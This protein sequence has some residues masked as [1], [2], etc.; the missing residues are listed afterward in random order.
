VTPR[1][2]HFGGT[3]VLDDD[4]TG[5]QA[6]VN[7]TVILDPDPSFLSTWT[8]DRRPGTVFVST[9]TRAMSGAKATALTAKIVD[10]VRGNW[11]TARFVMR[12]DSTLRGHVL[13]EYLG[14]VGAARPTL[15]LLPALP[16]AGRITRGGVHYIERDGRI[17]RLDQTEYAG[18]ADFA[19]TSSNLGRWAEERSSGLFSS[20]RTVV[21]EV[22]ELRRR[23]AAA[24][25]DTL[26]R[27][28]GMRPPALCVIDAEREDDLRLAADA[29]E[30]AQATGLRSAI[31]CG[32]DLAALLGRCHAEKLVT[33][34][35]GSRV[36]VIAG[37][38]V[39]T[40]TRQLRRLDERFPDS[41]AE[42]D[43]GRLLSEPEVEVRRLRTEVERLWGQ[44]AVATVATPRQTPAAGVLAGDLG[45]RVAEGMADL[46]RRLH[47]SADL[48][49]AKGGITAAVIAARAFGANTAWVEGPVRAGVSLWSLSSNDHEQGSLVVF[50]GNVGGNEDLA[51]LVEEATSA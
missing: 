51:D 10:A 30:E 35:R 3:V 49:V 4:P 36:L 13:E 19:Y 38:Y 18:D 12:G 1:S 31:R 42:V 28:E 43:L 50:P 2:H 29:L 26:R 44:S 37:S 23:G 14:V 25:T 46:V 5:A 17:V 24:L 15:V 45:R 6:S 39:P 47:A 48:V 32:P 9:N 22:A 20:D 21:L 40:T 11:P 34:P 7:V 41:A 33:V 8:A 27:A 16:R